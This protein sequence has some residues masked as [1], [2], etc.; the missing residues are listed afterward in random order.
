MAVYPCKLLIRFKMHANINVQLIGVYVER[1]L[2]AFELF[3]RECTI[4]LVLFHC[5]NR[6]SSKACL[7]K[8]IVSMQERFA[9]HTCAMVRCILQLWRVREK[10]ITYIDFIRMSQTVSILFIIATDIEQSK[11]LLMYERM[12]LFP[13]I[14]F[15]I[16]IFSLRQTDGIHRFPSLPDYSIYII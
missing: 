10:S 13:H 3:Q 8:E 2:F 9:I 12:S 4:T 6:I 15:E 1:R 16:R 14:L 7:S 5:R 11:Q